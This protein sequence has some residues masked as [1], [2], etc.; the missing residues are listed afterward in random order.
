MKL[1]VKF[2]AND[3]VIKSNFGEIYE[4]SDGGYDKGYSEGYEIG[5]ED[6]FDSGYNVGL[7]DGYTEGYNKAESEN[8]FYYATNLNG[9]FTGA[10]FPQDYEVVLKVQKA[11]SDSKCEYIF[12][13]C[14]YLK[15]AKLISEDKTETISFR[16]SFAKANDGANQST[17][18]LVDLTDF[19]RKFSSLQ[20]AFQHQTILKEIKGALDLSECTNV[21]N[22]FNQCL[23][24][25]DIEFVPNTIPISIN[26]SS[27]SKLTHD[28][29]MSIING[30]AT[31]TETKTLTLGTTNLAKLTDEEKA[32]ATQK[33]WSLA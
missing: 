25:E 13:N 29:L 4:V 16:S 30:L 28:S 32:I 15:T 21:T 5:K 9:V 31:V 24:L 6:G 7:K 10:A 23:A 33:N 17:L 11:Y 3:K 27:C 18:E 14:H 1:D 2:A 12:N 26:F 8:P 22:A 19:N 20:I